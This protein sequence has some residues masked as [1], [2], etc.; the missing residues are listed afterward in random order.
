MSLP[1][2]RPNLVAIRCSSFDTTAQPIARQL[3]DRKQQSP[4]P[5][6]RAKDPTVQVEGQAPR[7]ISIHSAIYNVFYLQRHHAYRKPPEPSE[8]R[9]SPSGTLRPPQS[10]Y[11]V[12]VSERRRPK[13]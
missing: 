10:H 8:R 9:H 11:Q 13:R 6:T 7:F 12:V 1:Y 3:P 2:A 4:G 5:T